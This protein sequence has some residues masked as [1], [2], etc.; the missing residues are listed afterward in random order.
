MVGQIEN[1]LSVNIKRS[2]SKVNARRMN[3]FIVTHELLR[4]C[5]GDMSQVETG[6]VI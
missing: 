3:T 4:V 5:V 2:M 1:E 6:L